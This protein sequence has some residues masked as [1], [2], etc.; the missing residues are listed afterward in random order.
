MQGS[1]VIIPP[2]DGDMAAY[3]ASL[4]KLRLL[5]AAAIAPGHGVFIERVDRTLR[6]LIRHRLQ[7]E[8]RVRDRLRENPGITLDE[9]LPMVYND[10][11]E[12]RFPIARFSLHAHLLKLQEEGEASVSGERWQLAA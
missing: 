10:V 9:L 4:E 8:A 5:D 1:T 12:D 2:P 3:I 11:P 7:R 6:G